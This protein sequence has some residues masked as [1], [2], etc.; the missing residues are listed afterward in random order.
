MAQ[1]LKDTKEKLSGGGSNYFK[2]GGGQS[3]IV[4]FLYRTI[5]DV[6]EDGFTAHVIPKEETGLKFSLEI[7]CAAKT[8]ETKAD[9]CIYCRQDKSRVGRYPLALY[10]ET[11][12]Q[13][14]YWGRTKK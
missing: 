12:K 9:D 3:A 1:K 14:E 7:L 2:L 11:T 8:D 10:N 5:D 6:I 4:R 13:I